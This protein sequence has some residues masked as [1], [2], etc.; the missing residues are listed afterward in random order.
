M[1]RRVMFVDDE[2]MVLHGLRRMLHG[3]RSE[4]DMVFAASGAEAISIMAQ[5]PADAVV[6]DMRMPGMNGAELLNR[7]MQDWPRTVR[8]IL[9]GHADQE[10]VLRCVGSTHQYLSKPCE[11]EALRSVLTRAF[12]LKTAIRNERLQQLAAKMDRLPSVPA[13][14]VEI[15][16]KAKDPEVSIEEI[17][18][19]ISRDIGMTAKVLHLV[20]SAF[21]GLRREISTPEEAVTYLGLETVRSLVLSL[22]AF[23]QFESPRMKGISL[24]ALWNHS[25][26]VAVAARKLATLEES[27]RKMGDGAFV[28][29]MLHDNGK[30]ILAYN[31]PDE[32]AALRKTP[33]LDSA[34]ML[35]A[36]SQA[37]GANHAEVGGYLLGLWGLPTPIVEAITFHHNPQASMASE[38]SALTL[39]HV[40]DAL[41]QSVNGNPVPGLDLDYLNKLSLADRVESWRE[42]LA[43]KA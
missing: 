8:I 15:V 23:G 39:V 43:E 31:F 11:P 20:N 26:Q 12:D 18:A 9:S 16:E 37:F 2:P 10:M 33:E 22:H 4:W 38:L 29:G 21:F 25:L 32:Y 42:A 35:E 13:L 41:T 17:G 14:Y 28:S 5:S 34:T 24:E 40:A 3:M 7:I 19:I 6:S 27:G 30:I 1:K 36:E